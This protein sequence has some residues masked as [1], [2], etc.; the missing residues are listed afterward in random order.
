MD[1]HHMTAPCGLPCFE[2]YAY[3]ANENEE[4][5]KMV[6]KELNLPLERAT[7]PGC[8]NA[9]GEPPLVPMSCNVYPCAEEKGLEHCGECSDFPCDHLHP[10]ADNHKRWH[11][12]KVFHLCLIRKMGLEEW[13]ENKAKSVFQTYLFEKF[14]L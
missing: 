8:R 4:L 7:C 10:Y 14:K 5:R 3:F 6:A 2:C 9:N 1:Y 12:T 13:A 11:N